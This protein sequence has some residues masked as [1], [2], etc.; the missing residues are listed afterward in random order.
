MSNV[1][2]Q[3]RI[4]KIA[5]KLKQHPALYVRQV[6]LVEF[7]SGL[8]SAVRNEVK[9]AFQHLTGY[10]TDVPS[11]A[12]NLALESVEFDEALSQ[13]FES[14]ADIVSRYEMANNI[15]SEVAA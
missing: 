2:Q 10:Q 1:T 3:L 13:L 8:K 4:E 15:E 9:D 14:V 12:L 5:S 11:C 6:E 7:M